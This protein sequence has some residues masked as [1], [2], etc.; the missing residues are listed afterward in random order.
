MFL[1]E[2]FRIRPMVLFDNNQMVKHASIETLYAGFVSIRLCGYW[3]FIF[4]Y[5][6]WN[7]CCFKSYQDNLLVT[8]IISQTAE[9]INAENSYIKEDY[10]PDCKRIQSKNK[11]TK[12]FLVDLMNFSSLTLDSIG[13]GYGMIALHISMYYAGL[14][15]SREMWWNMTHLLQF[16]CF[17]TLHFSRFWTYFELKWLVMIDCI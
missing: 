2:I 14:R 12:V 15:K 7:Y 6:I 4:W 17:E 11:S 9:D 3:R 16:Q 13:K 10:I 1:A 8:I 5:W